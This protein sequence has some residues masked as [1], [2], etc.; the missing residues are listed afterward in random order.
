MEYGNAHARP[1]CKVRL[2]RNSSSLPKRESEKD[3][4]RESERERE[5]AESKQNQDNNLEEMCPAVQS[6]VVVA[7]NKMQ[8]ETVRMVVITD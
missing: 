4:N 6:F 2:G 5:N 8:L 1:E 3:S 7:W